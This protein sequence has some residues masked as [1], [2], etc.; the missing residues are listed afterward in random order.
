MV[1]GVDNTNFNS[2]FGESW[3]K[4]TEIKDE[5]FG[6][7]S[8]RIETGKTRFCVRCVLL[9][10][11]NQI[12]VIKSEKY[13]YMQLPGGGIE[14]GESIID[15]LKREV[16][17]EAGVLIKDIKPMGYVLERREDT[18]NTHEWDRYVSFVFSASL[19]KYVGTNYV[20][21]EIGED[22]KPIWM[23]VGDFIAEKQ[24]DAKNKKY[25]GYF[26]DKRDLEIVKYYCENDMLVKK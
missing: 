22:F 5:D 23:E 4:I 21:D 19:D 13:G 6:F 7:N 20:G 11:N 14:N 8:T 17:E 25:S 16:R 3:R 18:Q 2:E 24:K 9:G 15:G 1:C 26:S 10:K 12:C